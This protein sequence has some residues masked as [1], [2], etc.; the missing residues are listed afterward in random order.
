MKTYYWQH[1]GSGQ[2]SEHL[3][4]NDFTDRVLGLLRYISRY[5]L[6]RYDCPLS[7]CCQVCLSSGLSV[8]CRA[9]TQAEIHTTIHTYC[10]VRLFR[11]FQ[12]PDLVRLP[13]KT[14]TFTYKQ[15]RSDLLAARQQR[16]GRGRGQGECVVNH[17]DVKRLRLTVSL[18]LFIFSFRL[19]CR[20]HSDVGLMP[21]RF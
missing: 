8:L 19:N 14:H 4:Q 5:I 7:V 6:R 18:S 15:T 2:T 11:S 12:I 17:G 13:E 10:G 21:E 16:R 1:S 3:N 9:F 20:G